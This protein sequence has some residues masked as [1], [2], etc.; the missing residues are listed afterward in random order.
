MA[1][2]FPVRFVPW[3]VRARVQVYREEP[4]VLLEIEDFVFFL[5]VGVLWYWTGAKIDRLLGRGQSIKQSRTA[6]AALAAMG[7]LFALGVGV[8]TMSYA[9]L[10]DAD[11]PL[12][13]LWPFG[14]VWSVMLLC[15][16]FWR[17]VGLYR[18]GASDEDPIPPAERRA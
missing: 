7:F 4:L 13:Q 17:L 15:Y 9:M 18:T 8:L 1:A 11:R 16:F 2:T 14:L 10:T 6:S 3:W 5:A 12:K